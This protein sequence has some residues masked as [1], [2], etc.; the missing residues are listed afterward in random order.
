MTDQRLLSKK[1]MKQKEDSFDYTIWLE[2]NHP[3]TTPKYEIWPLQKH[4]RTTPN[5]L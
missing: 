5:Q 1:K 2:P 3:S 4:P